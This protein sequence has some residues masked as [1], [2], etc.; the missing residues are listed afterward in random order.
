MS[1]LFDLC[2]NSL[3]DSNVEVT[4]RSI[5]L[6]GSQ[7]NF[8]ALSH[9]RTP[10]DAIGLSDTNQY[11]YRRQS[12]YF[13]ANKKPLSAVKDMIGSQATKAM[14]VLAKFAHHAQSCGVWKRMGEFNHVEAYPASYK[15]FLLTKKLLM[16]QTSRAN[17]DIQDA[18]ICAVSHIYFVRIV[19]LRSPS[20]RSSDQ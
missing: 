7:L 19:E 8:R 9:R 4:L 3:A 14:H 18:A 15:E 2:K 20:N 16:N 11:L 12:D 6:S 13:R 1:Q 17:E 10:Q 5:H